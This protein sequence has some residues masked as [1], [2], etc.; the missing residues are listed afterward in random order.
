MGN[1]NV[2]E[3]M[4]K[5]IAIVVGIIVVGAV[6][7]ASGVFAQPWEEPIE[8]SA[9]IIEGSWKHEITVE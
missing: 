6:L 7:Y 9:D 5:N 8:P 1:I 4:N 3:R 2:G